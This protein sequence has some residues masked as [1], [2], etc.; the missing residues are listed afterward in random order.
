MSAKQLLILLP[1]LSILFIACTTNTPPPP[2]PTIALPQPT[3]TPTAIPTAIPT[4]NATI[5][6]PNPTQ[7]ASAYPTITPPPTTNTIQSP[8]NTIQPLDWHTQTLSLYPLQLT[9][10]TSWTMIEKNRRPEPL[11]YWSVVFG[12]DCAE[13]MLTNPDNTLTLTLTPACGL[14]EGAGFPCPTDT[15]FIRPSINNQQ[16]SMIVRINYPNRN[17]Y[18]YTE[19]DMGLNTCADGYKLSFTDGFIDT[20]ML[21]QIDY[22]G[23]NT[24]LDRLMSITDDIIRS[25]QPIDRPVPWQKSPFTEAYF[26]GQGDKNI[27]IVGGIHAGYAPSSAALTAQLVAYYQSNYTTIP[28]DITLIIQPNMNPDAQF[29]PGDPIGRY[30]A[31]Q[32]D[33]N[34]NWDCNW[35]STAYIGGQLIEGAGG[36]TMEAEPESWRLLRLINNNPPSAAIFYT[37]RA[38]NGLVAPGKCDQRHTPS[39]TISTIYGQAA[40]YNLVN[41]TQPNPSTLTGDVTNRLAK[42]GI[43]A[44]F[45][46]LPDYQAVDF[47]ANLAGITAIINHTTTQSPSPLP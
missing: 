10:P 14:L 21:T 5:A 23:D 7:S 32:V 13:Y 46:L 30:N 35:Q 36:Q 34:R 37:A 40:G 1:F 11:G 8:A 3:T 18:A 26:F 42:Y 19:A 6:T 43:P 4:Q 2:S 24:D 47:E 33:L 16:D 15:L 44:I 28:D 39:E 41:Y 31:N 45:V 22:S 20:Y 29:A 9:L 27:L 25:L 12:H 38:T 17:T